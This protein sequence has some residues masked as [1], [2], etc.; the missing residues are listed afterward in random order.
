MFPQGR[1]LLADLRHNPENI[2][3]IQTKQRNRQFMAI[4]RKST[5]AADI[6]FHAMLHYFPQDGYSFHPLR[7]ERMEKH[8]ELPGRLNMG[9][10]REIQSPC[11]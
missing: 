6:K 10:Y 5:P 1:Y 9:F 7:G 3:P 11:Q 2:I 4:Y 8:Q